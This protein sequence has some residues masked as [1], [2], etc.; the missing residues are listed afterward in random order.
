METIEKTPA[1][2]ETR[3]ETATPEDLQRAQKLAIEKW[4]EAA[5]ITTTTTGLRFEL[6]QRLHTGEESATVGL[7]EGEDVPRTE[8]D[9]IVRK[10]FLTEKIHELE[11]LDETPKASAP[12]II[13]YVRERATQTLAA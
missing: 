5:R 7:E 6:K 12:K 3:L 2:I 13:E 8:L 1:E 11:A 9:R 4:H 10:A